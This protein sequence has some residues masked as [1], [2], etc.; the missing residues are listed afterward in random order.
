MNGIMC[1]I[2]LCSLIILFLIVGI[3]AI[4]ITF[5]Y[6]KCLKRKND[7]SKEDWKNYT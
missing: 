1:L 7:I 6:N 3:Y 2:A 5:V 4:I